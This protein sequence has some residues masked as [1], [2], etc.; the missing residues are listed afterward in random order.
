MAG[1]IPKPQFFR[2]PA[3]FRAWLEKHHA[4]DPEMWVGYYKKSSGKGGVVYREALDEALCFGWIDGLVK[5]IDGER[6]MQR[7]TP[8]KSTSHWSNVNVRRFEELDAEGRVH[9]AGRA[10]FERKTA[11]RTGKAAYEQPEA[12]LTPA[13]LKRLKANGKA[14]EFFSRQAPSYR[15]VVKHFVTR[16]KQEAT[17]ERRLDL[18]IEHSAK[19]ERLP[20]YLSPPGKK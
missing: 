8:R 4:T 17:R 9:P 2:T 14:W 11:D 15:R 18:V 7:Y 12:E 19:G 13:Q 20:Q 1:T 6:Y 10:A 3:E 5:S 16:A